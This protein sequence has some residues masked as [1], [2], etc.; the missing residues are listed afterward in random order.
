MPTPNEAQTRQAWIDPALERAG[1][2][3][4][5]PQRVRFEIPVDGYD[6]QAWQ[7]LQQELTIIKEQ[8]GIYEGALPPAA[9]PAG[10]CD[11]ALYRPNGEIIA[12]VE[13]KRT[14]VDPRLAEAQTRF[15]VTE[16]EKRQS[17]RPFGFMTNGREIYFYDVGRAPRRQV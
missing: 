14:S 6:P 3:L 5:D 13:A 17:F 9:L 15:Y 10:I 2:R 8:H 1:W 11:Y 4:D 16:I 12:V 7:A